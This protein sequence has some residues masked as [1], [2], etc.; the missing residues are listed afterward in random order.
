MPL[1]QHL[2]HLF[3][4]RKMKGVTIHF[5]QVHP[6]GAFIDLMID[7]PDRYFCCPYPV[8]D[9]DDL[10]IVIGGVLKEIGGV[11][12]LEYLDIQPQFLLPFPF[13]TIGKAF[14]PVQ[15]AA[16][17]LNDQLPADQFLIYKQ[18][19]LMYPDTVYSDVKAFH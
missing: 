18:L 2:T 15:T 3:V 6:E 4:D 8:V 12:M 11:E 16:G 5:V 1:F 17:K 14:S 13:Q 10:R 9:T 7:D 19:V